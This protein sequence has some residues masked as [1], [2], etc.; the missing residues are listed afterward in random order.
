MS[1]LI[2]NGYAVDDEKEIRADILIEN[3]VIAEVG[4]IDTRA[5]RVIDAE[6]MIV[7]PAFVE[8]HAHQGD[9]PG[10]LSLAA[11]SGGY[12][13][14]ALLPDSNPPIDSEMGIRYVEDRYRN[15]PIK[16]YPMGSISKGLKGE[17]LSE[18]G[19]M[20]S[21]GAVAFSDVGGVKDPMFISKALKYSKPT[22]ASLMFLPDDCGGLMNESYY[23]TLYGLAGIPAEIEEILV[24]NLAILSIKEDVHVHIMDISTEKSLEAL[25]QAQG[26]GTRLTSDVTPYHLILDEG[27]L[28][29]YDTNLKINPPLR[30]KHDIQALKEALREGLIDAISSDHKPRPR[31]AKYVEFSKADFGIS[32]IETVFSLMVTYLIEGGTIG[33]KDMVRLMSKGPSEVLGIKPVRIE[34]GCEADIVIADMSREFVLDKMYSAGNNPFIGKKLKGMVMYT[35]SSGE[36]AW[37]RGD[38]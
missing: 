7:M 19:R 21:A 22:D 15:L 30:S 6:G 18:M 16:V 34:Q 32:G 5:D 3:G 20:R 35:I 13:R 9:T 10:S 8:P 28:K 37:E 12:T 31:E 36:V 17:E 14:V 1:I 11:I 2:K 4:D 27:E 33:L 29:D 25:C 38:A 24:T 26:K 23:S